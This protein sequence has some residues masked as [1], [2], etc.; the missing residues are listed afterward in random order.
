MDLSHIKSRLS[1]M[2][3][4]IGIG[5][6]CL[7][8]VALLGVASLNFLIG[9]QGILMGFERKRQAAYENLAL[10]DTKRQVIEALGEPKATSP[11][12]NLPQRA[13]HEDCFQQ[14]EASDAV[15]FHQWINGGN[16]YYCIGYDANGR[17]VVKGEGHS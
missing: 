4:R 14:A 2:A 9:P 15:E 12:F 8:A 3:K 7:V 17:V 13:G 5:C 10:G 11:F 1:T 16:W 6:G